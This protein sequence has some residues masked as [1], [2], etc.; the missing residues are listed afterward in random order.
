MTAYFVADSDRI[1]EISKEAHA[2]LL[3]FAP[4]CSFTIDAGPGTTKA[5]RK[6]T[7]RMALEAA[8]GLTTADMDL[9]IENLTANI[10]VKV[11][12]VK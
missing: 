7:V 11:F 12:R 8:L 1:R 10:N 2:V 6:V 9:I 3:D 4:G 5:L